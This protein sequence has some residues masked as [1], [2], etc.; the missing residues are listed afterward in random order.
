MGGRARCITCSRARC[1]TPAEP[2]A[3]PATE[4]TKLPSPDDGWPDVSDFLDKKFG[5]MPIAM[6]ITEPAIGYG[7][8]GGLAFISEPLGNAAKGLGRPNITFVGGL[9]T[10]NGTWGVFAADLRYWA[11]DRVQTLVGGVYASVNLDFYGIGKGLLKDTPL[12]YTLQPAGGAAMAKYRFGDSLFWA[13]LGYAFASTKVTFEAPAGTPNIPDYQQ[14]SNVGMLLSLLTWDT[15]DNFFTP[16]SGTFLETAFQLSGKWLGGDQNFERLNLTAIQYLPLPAHFY[17][18]VRGDA[19][20]SFGDSPFYMNPSIGLRGVPVMRYQGQQIAELEMELRWQFWKRWSVLGFVG[21]G[22]AWNQLEKV[23]DSQGVI[24]GGGG[25]RY[26]LAKKYG[27]HMGADVAFSRDTAAFY[28]QFGSAW[29][30]P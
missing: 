13:G 14:R 21:G 15:R 29:M 28:I 3:P 8:V 24:S 25:F 6:P 18:G 27:I 11:D 17:F 23:E 20:S 1:I 16:V 5:F 30:R 12:R 26:E 10:A 7:A 19:A 22:G 4:P 9:G 2:A